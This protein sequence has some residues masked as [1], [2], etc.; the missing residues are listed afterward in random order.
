MVS[1]YSFFM[2]K[3]AYFHHTS[4]VICMDMHW[5]IITVLDYT[6]TLVL[7]VQLG[8]NIIFDVCIG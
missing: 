3:I 6:C 8:F 2:N 4:E 1:L 7:G 5:R